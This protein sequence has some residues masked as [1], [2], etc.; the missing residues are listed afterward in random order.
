MKAIEMLVLAISGFIRINFNE[1][2]NSRNDKREMSWK[3]NRMKKKYIYS[4][5]HCK[6]MENRNLLIFK[7]EMG[8]EEKMMNREKLIFF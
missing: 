1:S 8:W 6:K 2:E 7:N 4:I 5:S 3:W